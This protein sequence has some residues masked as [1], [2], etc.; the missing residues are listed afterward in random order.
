VSGEGRCQGHFLAARATPRNR[1]QSRLLC[2]QA[3]AILV[4]A[5]SGLLLADRCTEHTWLADP[6][7]AA[8]MSSGERRL[9]A[10]IV[11]QSRLLHQELSPLWDDFPTIHSRRAIASLGFCA[12]VRHHTTSQLELATCGL[13]L[14][15]TT[16]VRPA[17]EALVR[18]VWCN[19]GADDAWIVKFLTPPPEPSLHAGETA[20]SPSVQ[21][22]LDQLQQHHPVHIH[23]EQWGRR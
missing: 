1:G 12:V 7:G 13:D 2:D 20:M 8:H 14:S 3:G 19:G 4:R 6:T 5:G 17:F 11:E 15:A 18:A 16:L 10:R 23:R 22:M 21:C 9:L